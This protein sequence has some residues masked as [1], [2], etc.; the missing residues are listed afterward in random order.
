M[1]KCTSSRQPFPYLR[2]VRLDKNRDRPVFRSTQCMVAARRDH[3]HGS[4]ENDVA[5]SRSNESDKN[6]NYRDPFT[7]AALTVAG[8]LL[9]L[10]SGK[11]VAKAIKRTDYLH[12]VLVLLAF[13]VFASGLL[14]IFF[15][16]QYCPCPVLV[17]VTFATRPQMFPI[18]HPQA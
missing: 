17:V 11:L 5:N 9:L 14:T 7:K 6:E 8:I 3:P 12:I 10:I 15:R 2:R 4:I 13:P 1:S 16:F 18:L